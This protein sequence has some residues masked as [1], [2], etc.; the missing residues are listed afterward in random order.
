M[1]SALVQ[2]EFEFRLATSEPLHDFDEP[3][4][5]AHRHRAVSSSVVHLKVREPATKADR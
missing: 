5:L 2:V 3:F 4:C 1:P